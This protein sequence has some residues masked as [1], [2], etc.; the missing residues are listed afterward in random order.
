MHQKIL[1]WKFWLRHQSTISTTFQKTCWTISSSY[2]ENSWNRVLYYLLL[3]NLQSLGVYINTQY[4]KPSD[5]LNRSFL[6]REIVMNPTNH[7]KREMWSI[8]LQSKGMIR[9]LSRKRTQ[10]A[11]WGRILGTPKCICLIT[12]IMG[13]M[14]WSS[15]LKWPYCVLFHKM[16]QTS[17]EAAKIFI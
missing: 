15:D 2:K 8:Y 10:R 6:W 14:N 16:N 5:N 7:S 11:Y 1:K 9:R 12:C 17:P 3:F 13:A 4:W